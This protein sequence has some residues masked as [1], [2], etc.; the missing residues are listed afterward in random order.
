MRSRTTF[1]YVHL[2]ADPVPAGRLEMVEDRRNS[3]ATFQYGTRYLRRPIASPSIRRLCLCQ[4]PMQH[5]GSSTPPRASS[6][7][8][9]SV[10]PLPMVGADT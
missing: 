9:E 4:I 2:A 10:M 3:Y 6:S 1:V 8:T 7:S 5:L